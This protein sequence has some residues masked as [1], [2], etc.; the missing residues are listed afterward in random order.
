MLITVKKIIS[1]FA[2]FT[3]IQFGFSQ[4]EKPTKRKEI[5]AYY[6]NW[7]QYKRGGMFHQ[8]NI[9]FS[10]Y[11]MINYG[12]M[13]LNEYGEIYLGDPWGDGLILN[14]EIDWS[15]TTDENDPVYV[16]YSNM[17]GMAHK[18]G[19]K[20]MVSVGGWTWSTNFP[21]VAADPKLRARFAQSCVETC[22]KYDF[23]GI[24]LDWEFPGVTPGNGCIGGPEDKENFNLMIDQIR[25]SL[26]VY[27][28]EV[29][30]EMH[31]TA[32][33]HAVPNIAQ[34]IDW[35]H[36]SKTLDYV[37][38]FGYDFYG[39]WSAMANHN[40]PLY[41]PKEGT[42]GFNISDAFTLM[43]EVYKVPAEKL[44][45]GVGFYGRTLQG[46]KENKLFSEHSGAVDKANFPVHEGSPAYY[47]I[48]E[49]FP[50]YDV[51]WDDQAKV[52]YMIGKKSNSFV[53]YDDL[54][55]IQYKA[56]FLCQQKT[57]GCL[58][59]E[60]S[61]DMI[62]VP[63]GSA[64]IGGTPLIDV[65]NEVFETYEQTGNYD[66]YDNKINLRDPEELTKDYFKRELKIDQVA[67]EYTQNN[68]EE[69]TDSII[70]QE[71]IK[72]ELIKEK[73][74]EVIESVPEF[75]TSEEISNEVHNE[76]I[77]KEI[78]VIKAENVD[79]ENESTTTDIVSEEDREALSDLDLSDDSA[80]GA[81]EGL[82][83]ERNEL[84]NG[85][86]FFEP[87]SLDILFGKNS[88][89]LNV[90]AKQNIKTSAKF[91]VATGQQL[92]LIG[93]SS[94]DGNAEY[95]RKLSYNRVSAVE[96]FLTEQIKY[97][98]EAN[99]IDITIDDLIHTNAEGATS[100]FGSNQARNR[101]VTISYDK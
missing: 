67:G 12:F 48:I 2:L 88:Y 31:L 41:P 71:E 93:Y 42:F 60:M 97:Y 32:V 17:V 11:T 66:V 38:F 28:K 43:T 9:D 29:G 61:L 74:A 46:L 62:E 24:D 35:E 14:G 15:L 69:K 98:A 89:E 33:F 40:A 81:M 37:L 25:D 90:S 82:T 3:L 36:V 85:E 65:L 59:W 75:E 56:A 30:H 87:G 7:E 73:E 68:F 45:I 86:H 18:E 57:A 47:E 19:T 4:Q 72:E 70:D 78:I 55:S 77:N 16:P 1:V 21:T 63:Q 58:I 39:P 96:N 8:K 34:H 83:K 23:D 53:S 95:N 101:R 91:I 49:K 10:K 54:L 64:N 6:A 5:V 100:D 52:P 20:V 51:L 84:R 22:R 79:L 13:G 50:E 44:I 27:E 94:A 76:K 80:V 26:D 99:D 92:H